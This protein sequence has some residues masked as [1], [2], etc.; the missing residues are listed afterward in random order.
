MILFVCTGNICRSPM[1]EGFAR[2]IRPDLTFASGGT[3]PV[4]GAAPTTHAQNVM[5]E[6]DIDIGS[7]RSARI[8]HEAELALCM[9]AE[10]L[11][12]MR[13]HR[14]AVD[15]EL[16]MIDGTDVMDPYGEDEHMYRQIRD[17]IVD[18]L[19]LRLSEGN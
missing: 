1:A 14:P 12:W 4:L 8:P 18:A 5:R 3:H 16:L 17:Q 13:S 7:Q 9:T 10:H 15:A 11:A 2:A 6:L 19:R